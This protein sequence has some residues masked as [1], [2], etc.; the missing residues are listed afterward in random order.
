MPH[1]LIFMILKK[2]IFYAHYDLSF[3]IFSK[4]IIYQLYP[5]L[6]SLNLVEQEPKPF[7]ENDSKLLAMPI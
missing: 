3:F 1:K 2:N 7:Q 6:L 5:N 4:K